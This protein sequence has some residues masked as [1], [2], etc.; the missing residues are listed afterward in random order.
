MIS[1]K[2]ARWIQTTKENHN[3]TNKQLPFTQSKRGGISSKIRAY[4]KGMGPT[5]FSK[6]EGRS[7]VAAGE[8]G[9]RSLEEKEV[10]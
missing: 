4:L 8:V 10:V 3:N 2:E 1:N 9:G 5:D 6:R 7:K